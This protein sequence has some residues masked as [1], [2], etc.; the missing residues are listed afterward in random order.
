MHFPHFNV[1]TSKYNLIN[2]VKKLKIARNFI[3]YRS[4]ISD[5]C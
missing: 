4:E 1:S 3:L 5:I 2:S